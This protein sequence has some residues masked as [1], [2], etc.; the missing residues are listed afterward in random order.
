MTQ[1][2]RGPQFSKGALSVFL[3]G[4]A[5]GPSWCYVNLSVADSFFLMPG[6]SC[7]PGHS[8]NLLPPQLLPHS[9]PSPR[10]SE[11]CSRLASR[12]L[13]IPGAI[14]KRDPPPYIALCYFFCELP[15]FLKGQC[16]YLVPA[17]LTLGTAPNA[18]LRLTRSTCLVTV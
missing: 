11:C 15:P 6:L 13:A 8:R 10:D 14:P 18:F 4:C 12:L 17:R 16:R 1:H 5:V 2:G 7:R 3:D 9:D